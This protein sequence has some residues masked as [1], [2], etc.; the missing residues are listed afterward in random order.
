MCAC[1]LRQDTRCLRGNGFADGGIRLGLP[2]NAPQINNH[3]ASL[4]VRRLHSLRH[5]DLLWFCDRPL[6]NFFALSL[7]FYALF[8]SSSLLL[9]L[10]HRATTVCSI[11]RSIV[12][13]FTRLEAHSHVAFTM[14]FFSPAQAL[15]AFS[16]LSLSAVRLHVGALQLD[17]TSPGTFLSMVR[18]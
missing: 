2:G 10:P 6:L 8:S 15:A 1:L 11:N 14:R 9:L 17:P 5:V 7:S 4:Q 16:L 12:R 13:S 3:R 18:V